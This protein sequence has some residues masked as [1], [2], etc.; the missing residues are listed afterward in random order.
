V[1]AKAQPIYGRWQTQE[2]PIGTTILA[3][4]GRSN[5]T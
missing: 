4:L 5:C 1:D 3:V 2:V